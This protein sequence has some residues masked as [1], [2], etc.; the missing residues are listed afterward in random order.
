MD[1]SVI[2]IAHEIQAIAQNGLSFSK[3]PYDQDRFKQLVDVASMLVARHTT[4]PKEYIDRVF[5]AEAGYVTPKLDVRAAVFRDSKILMVK[6]RGSSGWTL[7]GGFVDVNESLS[8]AVTRETREESG[9]IVV[10]KK[11]CGIYD[12][13]KHGYKPH[14]YH[15]YKI[16]VL[17][18]VSGGEAASSV[19]TS[20]IGFFARREI[21][22][23][24][25]DIGRTTCAHV[26]RMFDHFGN[27][28]LQTDFD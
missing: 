17:C 25:L 18:D 14:L 2:E 13:R 27:Q 22:A 23:L 1:L 20:E 21:E 6:E 3:D 16:Y 9:F 11:V 8:K 12:H 24:F 7:P 4:H 19:E 5:S 28:A 26:L 10:P 15:F